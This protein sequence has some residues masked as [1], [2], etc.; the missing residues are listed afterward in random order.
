MKS[1]T[2]I[3]DTGQSD[4]Q[5]AAKPVRKLKLSNIGPWSWFVIDYAIAYVCATLAFWLTPHSVEI[6]N[7]SVTGVHIGQMAF[8]FGFGLCLALVAHIAGL[9]EP[10]QR[11]TSLKLLGSCA[12]VTLIAILLL[13]IELLLVHYFVVG[14]LIT[15]YTFIACTIGLFVIRALVVGLTDKHVVGFVGSSKFVEKAPGVDAMLTAQGVKTV[16]LLLNEQENITLLDWA[17]KNGV[18][19]VVVDPEDKL[20][21][22]EAELLGLINNNFSVSTYTNFIEKLYQ[23][24][25]NDHINAKWIIDCLAEQTVI[26]NSAVKRA[27]DIIVASIAL[28]LLSP[29]M[30]I[31]AIAVK[32]DSPGPIIFRQTR[33]GQF[34]ELFTMFK[35][36]TMVQHAEANGAQWAQ[37]SD[38]RVTKVGQFLRRSRIDEGPQLVNVL[39]GNMSLVGPRPER[40]EFTRELETRIPFFVHRVLVK[41]GITGWAQVNAGYAATEAEAATKLSFDLY[42]VK[43]MSFGLDLRV[44]LRTISSFASGAR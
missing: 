42:Y 37:K 5:I 33:V 28:V 25:P 21:P 3:V 36:R 17:N 40:P 16:T 22:T 10:I 4:V 29:V 32:L 41:P 12:L 18:N 11:R 7:Q 43:N 2:A 30:L 34:G 1:D 39:M 31:A 15:F 20:V 13:N 6:Q 8:S 27:I 23:R 9:H 44:L 26:Y 38:A 14:R 35:I 19:E 24:I